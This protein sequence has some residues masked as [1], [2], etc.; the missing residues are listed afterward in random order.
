[1]HA[2]ICL[3]E[4]VGGKGVAS[5]GVRVWTDWHTSSYCW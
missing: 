4:S 3:C 2:S 1:M 5:G